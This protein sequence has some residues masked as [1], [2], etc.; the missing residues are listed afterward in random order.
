MLWEGLSGWEIGGLA[1]F[2]F[3]HFDDACDRPLG[4]PAEVFWF[5]QI[6]KLLFFRISKVVLKEA[7]WRVVRL[8]T[9]LSHSDPPE[10]SPCKTC[11]YVSSCQLEAC[12][13]AVKSKPALRLLEA[14]RDAGNLPKT[15][16]SKL[17]GIF[18]SSGPVICRKRT[19]DTQSFEGLSLSAGRFED[20]GNRVWVTPAPT[21]PRSD[22]V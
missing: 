2:I 5:A 13:R 9:V 3:L 6:V 7:F 12:H 4:L 20:T 18:L 14:L 15:S 8:E 17:F 19:F 22:L 16:C 10:K 11:S 1:Q 21:K